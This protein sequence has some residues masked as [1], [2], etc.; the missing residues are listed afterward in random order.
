M[1]LG[2]SAA[3]LFIPRPAPTPLSKQQEYF[4]GQHS[5]RAPPHHPNPPYY[6]MER[7][8]SAHPLYSSSTV[9]TRTRRSRG[10]WGCRWLLQSP[11][12]LQ[13]KA[14]GTASTAST[15]LSSRP[16]KPYLL[17]WF[18]CLHNSVLRPASGTT[19]RHSQYNFHSRWWYH[20]RDPAVRRYWR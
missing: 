2:A 4:Q 15:P 9:C 10:D 13:Q 14:E 19:P 6:H 11:L 17:C 3:G 18:G 12:C 8:R 20:F 1:Q 16:G 7:Q 5:H